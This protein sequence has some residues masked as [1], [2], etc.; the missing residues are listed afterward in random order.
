M[1][2]SLTLARHFARLVWLLTHQSDA[3]SEQKVALRAVAFVSKEASVR[4]SIKK[5]RLAVNGL[6]MPQALTGVQELA[7]RLAGHEIEEIEIKQGAKPKE[8]LELAR[9]LAIESASNS[10]VAD[11]AQRLMELAGHSVTVRLVEKAPAPA[12]ESPSAPTEAA[13]PVSGDERV[14][15]LF[16][17]LSQ[18][19]NVFEAQGVLDEIG[20]VAEKCAREGRLVETA[21][22]F[23][24]IIDREAQITDS[25]MRRAH[26]VTLRRLTKPTLLRPVAEL[27][28]ADPARAGQVERIL[29]R[30][31]QDGVDAA[32][33]RYASAST[34]DERQRYRDVLFRL[35]AARES[36]E[37]MLA[38]SRW[39]IV[40]RAADLLGEMAAQE[41]ERPL[42]DLLRNQDP[43]VRRAAVR[44][45]GRLDGSFAIDAL[46]RG[47]EDP[48]KAVRLEAIAAL[49]ARRAAP[50][51]GLPLAKAMD[52]EA[53]LDVQYVLVAAL[54][55]V[56]TAE[57]VQKLARAAEA[58]GMFKSKKAI[59]LRLAAIKALG[60]ARTPAA[61]A[62]L[63]A[64][65]SDRDK[66]VAD[67]AA[68][69]MSSIPRAT[70]AVA[71]SAVSGVSEG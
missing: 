11:F 29:E 64:L 19:S 71:A 30:C 51:A 52:D 22:V 25:E 61:L 43:R 1:D 38:D 15:G 60:E 6:V 13:A 54:G 67:T 27:L 56:A 31:G 63:Q 4:L 36:L 50:R 21:D 66:E 58:G 35:P 34:V 41:A 59:G 57:A 24:G 42:A 20:F 65:R 8:L 48:A 68:K 12:P 70:A 9:L 16:L 14:Q 18:V 69:T 3:K 2:N 47:V 5:K 40:R 55:R 28:F 17:R 33:D 23:T 37:R 62:A 44:A 39:F 10:D 32:V 49:A 46:A 53:E 45:L 26:L 7:E